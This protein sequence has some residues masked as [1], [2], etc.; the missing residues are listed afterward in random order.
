MDNFYQ[1]LSSQYITEKCDCDKMTAL[2]NKVYVQGSELD[3]KLVTLSEAYVANN[4]L[5][6]K[7]QDLGI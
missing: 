5:F 7:G 4:H 6:I 2:Y 3:K 1:N